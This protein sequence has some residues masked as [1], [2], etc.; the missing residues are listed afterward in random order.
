MNGSRYLVVYVGLIFEHTMVG[1]LLSAQNN[2]FFLDIVHL[3]AYN[4]RKLA[5]R[6]KQCVSWSSRKQPT[7]SRSSTEAEYNALA[8]A[9][10][11]IIW[12][13]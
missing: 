12:V 8:N 2:V 5:F 6:S 11:E 1:N 3:Q 13:Q 9:T 4:G 7:V 10:I